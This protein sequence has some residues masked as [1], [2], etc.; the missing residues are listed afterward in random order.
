MLNLPEGRR[1]GV[2]IYVVLRDFATE[3]ARKFRF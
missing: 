1:K 2:Y 3:G